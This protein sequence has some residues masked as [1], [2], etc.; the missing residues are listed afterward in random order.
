MPSSSGERACVHRL[1]SAGGSAGAACLVAHVREGGG[2][3]ELQLLSHRLALCYYVHVFISPCGA[4]ISAA[5][6]HPTNFACPCRMTANS[7]MRRVRILNA[8]SGIYSWG[9][10]FNTFSE[11][12]LQSWGPCGGMQWAFYTLV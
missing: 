8:D 12:G 7:F 6:T 5:L 4:H 11:V 3:A 1:G 2:G 9:S 10:I